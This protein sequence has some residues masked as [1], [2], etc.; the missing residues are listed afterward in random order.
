MYRLIDSESQTSLRHI[1]ITEDTYERLPFNERR[2]YKPEREDQRFRD[3][4]RSLL[5]HYSDHHGSDDFGFD[6]PATWPE[7]TD[8]AI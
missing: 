4:G 1:R 2:L 5:D 3:L 8:G 7:T 6:H